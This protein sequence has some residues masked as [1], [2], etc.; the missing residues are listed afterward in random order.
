M[1]RVSARQVLPA[2]LG[3]SLLSLLVG[4]L[5]HQHHQRKVDAATIQ[6]PSRPPFKSTASLAA[7]PLSPFPHK[8]VSSNADSVQY[9]TRELDRATA[10]IVTVPAA[11]SVTV[12]IAPELTPVAAIAQQAGATVAINAGFFDPQNG[13]T[14]SHVTI[15][16]AVA[17]DPRRNARLMDNPDLAPY[18]DQILN[19]SEFRRYR[20]GSEGAS[21]YAIVAH[22]ASSPEG[23]HLVDAVGGGP[24]LLPKLTSVDEGFVATEN[25]TRIRD[26]IGET[27]P[28]ARSAVGLT[29]AGKVLLVAVAQHPNISGSGLSLVELADLMR[30]LGAETALN[31]DGGSSTTLYYEGQAY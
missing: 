13:Q 19:R 5:E 17:A 11:Y 9:S 31:L 6:L 16:G 7:N 27:Q 8:G 21:Q 25:G 2:L 23:C 22:D 12:A 18:L 4:K 20:C 26:A 28:N 15:D 24:Q 3:A 14:T 29:A 10:H 1:H 30:S